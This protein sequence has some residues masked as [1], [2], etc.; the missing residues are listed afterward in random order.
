MVTP[1]KNIILYSYRYIFI[2]S[3]LET[4]LPSALASFLTAI[5]QD[6]NKSTILFYLG[7]FL[8]VY[9][10]QALLTSVVYLI[11]NSFETKIFKALVDDVFAHVYLLP[12]KFF[13]NTF[14]GSIVSKVNRARQK[15]EVFEDQILFYV[16][17][18]PS[19]ILIGSLLFLAFP[20]PLC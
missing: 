20:L 7:I 9:L 11:Y 10:F 19:L 6:Q 16:F 14:T 2:A 8:G 18:Q 4:Y 13:A 12:E 3:F 15:I 1:T 17:F 5:R